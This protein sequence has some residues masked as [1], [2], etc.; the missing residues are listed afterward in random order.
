MVY[1]QEGGRE[2]GHLPTEARLKEYET[3]VGECGPVKGGR[4][5]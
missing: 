4:V 3:G 2:A 5:E 1:I